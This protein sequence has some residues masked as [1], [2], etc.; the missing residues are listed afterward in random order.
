[1]I[2]LHNGGEDAHAGIHSLRISRG[3]WWPYAPQPVA[4]KANTS[5]STRRGDNLEDFRWIC[6]SDIIGQAQDLDS[7]ATYFRD[8]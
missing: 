2:N 7:A 6:A 1:M 3:A 5:E 4:I 8:V